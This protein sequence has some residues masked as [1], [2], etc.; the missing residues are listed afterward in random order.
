MEI[1]RETERKRSPQTGD[2]PTHLHDSSREI[3]ERYQGESNEEYLQRACQLGQTEKALLEINERLRSVV[4]TAYDPIIGAD[5][6]GNIM[7]WNSAAARVFG[8][9]AEEVMNRPVTI[10]MPERFVPIHEFSMQRAVAVGRLFYARHVREVFGLKKDGT[11]FPMEISLSATMTQE[12]MV[13]TAIVRD[14]TERK[15][16][17]EELRR[18]N[19]E[20][21]SRVAERTAEL[22][23]SNEDL[24]QEIRERKRVEEM[25]RTSEQLYH[26]LVEEVPDVI[27]VLNDEGRFTYLNAQAEELLRR[28]LREILDTPLALHVVP[29]QREKIDTIFQLN[30]DSIWDEE[31]RLLD[32]DGE[33]RFARIRCKAL[34][35]DRNG[36]S[37]YEGVMRDITRRRRLEEQLQ[38]SR[39][40]LLEKIRIIDDL[41]AHIVESR[42]AKAIVQHTAEVAH[43]LR[44]PLTIIGGFARRIDRQL[45]Q[46][47][48]RSDEGKADAVQI[49][50]NEV[51]RLERILNTLL[52]FTRRES[53]S[54]QMVNPHD[55]INKVITFY[56]GAFEEKDLKTNFRLRSEVGNIFVDPDRFEQVVR[57]LVAN[58][59]DASPHGETLYIETGISVPSSKALEAAALEWDRYFEMKVR[60]CGPAIKEEDMQKIFSPFF[61]TKH[62]GTGIGLTAAKKIVEAHNGSISV[63]SD[64]SGTTFTVWLPLPQNKSAARQFG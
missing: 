7:M 11:E 48:L 32:A 54:Q 52:D 17:E 49:I 26:T 59:I 19:E 29:D 61:T 43:E 24:K 35:K 20:L 58:A 8:Y 60:N 28:P 4:E 33:M 23:K 63:Q 47:K 3:P 38:E 13:F 5:R 53:V 31:I 46:C 10:L 41:Y 6:F 44:Q 50:C 1:K 57:N 27:F 15:R 55:I 34:G 42:K 12:G 45:S 30:P 37:S 39:E 22:V 36:D 21:E 2:A 18:A 40:Q 62:Y 16:R 14:I 51:R 56:E 25:L 64:D 9:S